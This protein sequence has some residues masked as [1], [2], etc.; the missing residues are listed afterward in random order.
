MTISFYLV[1]INAYILSYVYHCVTRYI[2]ISEYYLKESLLNFLKL[3]T[4]C[5]GNIYYMETFYLYF[6]NCCSVLDKIAHLGE[7]GNLKILLQL[8]LF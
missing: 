2:I 8:Y 5:K 7:N 1:K 3:N 6:G 4:I